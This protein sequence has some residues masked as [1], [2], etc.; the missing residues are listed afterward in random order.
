[1]KRFTVLIMVF[2][3]LAAALPAQAASAGSIGIYAAAVCKDTA[4]VSVSGTSTWTTNRV[5]VRMYVL[6]DKNEYKLHREAFSATFGSGDFGFGLI[7]DY[8]DKPVAANKAMR[9]DVT[10]Q[11]QSG[12]GFAEVMTVSQYANAADQLCKDRCAL[13][14]TTGDKAPANGTITVRTHYGSYFRPEGRLHAAIPVTAGKAVFST[15]VAVPCDWSVRVWYY[16]AT[17]KDRTPRLLPSQ[18]WPGEFGVSLSNP[19]IP[20]VGSFAKGLPATRP[21]EAGD[22]YAPK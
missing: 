2:A 1:M 15:V 22:P 13:T 11:R 9:L 16:P 20:Y 5:R 4:T 7:V 18:Y 12:S 17:G 14:I 3:L 19:A 8:S 6:N 10:L 21:L